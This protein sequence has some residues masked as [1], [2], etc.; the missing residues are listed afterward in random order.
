MTPEERLDRFI[1]RRKQGAPRFSI[2]NADLASRMEAAEALISLRAIEV[3]PE[4]AADLESRLRAHTR[5]NSKGLPVPRPLEPRYAPRLTQRRRWM[6]AL[7][8]V[9]ALLLLCVGTL[10][11]AARSLPG[12]PLYGLKQFEYQFALGFAGNQQDRAETE[13]SQLRSELDDLNTVLSEHRGDEA[14]LQAL[15]SVSA[16][17]SAS[18]AAVAELPAG[19]ERITAQS[20]LA[21]LLVEEEQS[22]RSGLPGVDWPLRLAFTQQLGA[23]GDAVPT[24]TRVKVERPSTGM[25]T[26]TVTGTNFAPGAALTINGVPTGTA[27]STTPTT[28]VVTLHSSQWPKGTIAVGVLNPDGT[29]AQV[30]FKASNDDDN[31]QDDDQHGQ[32]TPGATGT[33]GDDG[34]DDPGGGE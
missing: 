25:V 7:G 34:H 30:T 14:I 6:T 9:A 17:T 19:A 5:Q 8:L 15:G 22:L 26:I 24:V 4:F 12:D 2:K 13:L 16:E 10:T 32:G 21:S 1:E 33:P 11:A 23:L 27:S 18:Q 31:D 3:P 28:L 29:A 20:N